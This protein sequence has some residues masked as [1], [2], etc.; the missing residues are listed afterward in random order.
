MPLI[1]GL[2]GYYNLGETTRI[3]AKNEMH[4]YGANFALRR[5]LFQRMK[6]FDTEFGVVGGQPGRG[7]ETEYF[8]RVKEERIK[9]VYVGEAL[10]LHAV[11][12]DHLKLRFLYQYGIQKGREV[13]QFSGGIRTLNTFGELV[14][15]VKGFFQ[16]MKGRGD[17]FRQC[18]INLGIVK[19]KRSY[20]KMIQKEI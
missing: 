3:Y 20:R 5:S 10:I 4:P 1:S 15:L 11:Q 8:Q 6:L 14:L 17:R 18:V 19:G 9:G 13:A 16:L 2:L 7:E 12:P